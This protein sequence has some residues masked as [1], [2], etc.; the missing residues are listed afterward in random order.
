M[1]N[2]TPA[3]V[4][5]AIGVKHPN[6]PKWVEL[7][8]ALGN[9][10]NGVMLEKIIK[11]RRPN[12]SDAT[13][14]YRCKIF[15]P[16]TSEP[17]NK[18][19]NS[20]SK[21][22]RS[23]DW[24]IQY[25]EFK[26]PNIA[27]GEYLEDYCEFNF[28]KYTSITN[29]AFSV[30]LN[31]SL[32]DANAVCAVILRDL[33][34]RE[35]NTVKT[36]EYP[37]PEVEI[38]NSDQICDFVP[39]EY[40][41]LKSADVPVR[42]VN[43]QKVYEGE[44]YYVLTTTQIFKYEYVMGNIRE[45]FSYNHNIGELPV[46]KVGGIIYEEKN[47][48]VIQK[49]RIASMIPFLNEAAREYSDLQAEIVQHAHSEK[50]V[51][52]NTECPDCKGNGT[53]RDENKK[54]IK[55][56]KCSG[57]GKLVVSQYGEYVIDTAKFGEVNVPNSPIGYVQ[58]DTNMPKFMDDH[59]KGHIY[60]ALSSVNMEF[61]AEKPL[62]Q[63]GTAKEIDQ[64]E[65]NNFVNSV[66]EDIVMVLDKV[67]KFIADYRYSVLIPDKTELAKMLP[68]IPVPE[69]FG[70]VGTS[71]L[72]EE[73]QKAKNSKTNPVLIK[74]MEIEFARKKYNASPEVADELETIFELDAFYGY[75]QSEKMTM[76]NNNGITMLD[77]VI[78]CNIEQFVQRA[79]K[80]KEGFFKLSYSDKKAIIKAFAEEVIKENSVKEQVINDLKTE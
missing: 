35:D 39:D 67:Y 4:K 3:F 19:L 62:N 59:V 72:M 10:A 31:K 36:N 47:N 40:C 42:V 7:K 8:N 45:V 38:F 46:F 78:S 22:R 41:V 17:I 34:R 18:V 26:K 73:I 43:G 51:Y 60:K 71:Y 54:L 24:V 80:E 49:S 32:I 11:E 5:T 75:D 70:L 57:R 50:F 66:A 30:L 56:E 16:I 37:K 21:I 64:D 23:Q 74:N 63:S 13:F 58:K 1:I 61:L 27:E 44:I 53:I 69:R 6:Q 76:L 25:P 52:S 48:D 33:P 12:E 28:P 79:A 15:E 55:C 65:I 2:V 29:W 68:K 9:H 77:Y 14:A 20:L